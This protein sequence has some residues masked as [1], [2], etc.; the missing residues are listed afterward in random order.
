MKI[1]KNTSLEELAAI[2]SQA[3]EEA[4]ILAT[5]S[6]GSAVSLFTNNQYQSFDLDFITA[7]SRTD[8]KKAI[9]PLGYV[10]SE[11]I[12]QFEHPDSKWLVEFPPSPLGFGDLQVDAEE[13]PVLQTKYGPIRVISPTLSVMDRLA[14][15]WYHSDRQCWDQAQLLALNCEIDW[16][17]V[18]EWAKSE[19]QSK[20]EI[21]QLRKAR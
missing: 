14:A 1:T 19:G 10:E 16:K 4:G 17:A 2:I 15:Y 6:G 20:N 5:L 11:N 13:I 8:L 12:R 18:L 21:E 9:A 7:A 3:L